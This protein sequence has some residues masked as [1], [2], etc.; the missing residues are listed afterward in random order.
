[1]NRMGLCDERGSGVDRI[2]LTC[3]LNQ[4]PAPEFSAEEDFTRAKLFAH[5]G[6]RDLTKEDKIRA[7]YYHAVMKHLSGTYMTNNSLRERFGIA[8]AN[9]PTASGIIK[10]ALEAKVIKTRDEETTSKY[11]PYWA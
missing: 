6:L 10:L 9:Y 11:V 5:K 8:K 4:L 7:A 1:M 3:E 2:V